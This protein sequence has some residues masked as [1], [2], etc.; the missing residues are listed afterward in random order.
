MCCLHQR[1]TTKRSELLRRSSPHLVRMESSLLEM[2]VGHSQKLDVIVY[3]ALNM[4]IS[5]TKSQCFA[6]EGLHRGPY[7][8]LHYFFGLQ[9]R[10][11]HLLPLWI[12]KERV[13]TKLG[14]FTFWSNDPFMWCFSIDW[15]LFLN[16][17]AQYACTLLGYTLQ[18]GGASAELLGTIKQL[19]SHMSLTRKCK[20]SKGTQYSKT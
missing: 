12:L 10:E 18:K 20:L 4:D 6:S 8:P 15:Y 2:C 7:F 19:E 17:A 16:R 5:L 11:H 1:K 14:N 13:N 3:K 9:N